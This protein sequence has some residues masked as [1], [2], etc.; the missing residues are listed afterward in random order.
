MLMIFVTLRK[1]LLLD[2]LYLWSVYYLLTLSHCWL[3]LPPPSTNT[4][5][6]LECKF[7]KSV[8]RLMMFPRNC[9]SVENFREKTS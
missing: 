2:Q 3:L 9:C 4:R 8:E 7:P 5:T 6:P 1:I